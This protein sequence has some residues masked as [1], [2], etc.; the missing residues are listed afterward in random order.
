MGAYQDVSRIRSAHGLFHSINDSLNQRTLLE[1]G[2][3]ISSKDGILEGGNMDDSENTIEGDMSVLY[4][5][6]T[7]VVFRRADA[8]TII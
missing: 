3:D 2:R 4:G 6:P 1:W 5:E 7:H 8:N